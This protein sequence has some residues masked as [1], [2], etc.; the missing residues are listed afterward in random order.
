MLYSLPVRSIATASCMCMCVTNK[1]VWSKANLRAA[2][3]CVVILHRLIAA[4]TQ[5]LYMYMQLL[6]TLDL[7]VD[8]S[9]IVLIMQLKKTQRSALKICS[10]FPPCTSSTVLLLCTPHNVSGQL[11]WASSLNIV[12]K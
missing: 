5:T 12:G 9:I 4:E 6:R 11:H 3:A 10:Q 1:G 2:S 7:I 8:E